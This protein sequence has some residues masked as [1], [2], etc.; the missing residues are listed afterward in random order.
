MD[1]NGKGLPCCPTVELVPFNGRRFCFC[2]SGRR[3][4]SSVAF[5]LPG[6]YPFRNLFRIVFMREPPRSFVTIAG[7]VDSVVDVV[8]VT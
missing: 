8:T 5:I 3:R 6:L 2:R 4:S 7:S 1:D